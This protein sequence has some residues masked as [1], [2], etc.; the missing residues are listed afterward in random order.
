MAQ[1]K[2]KDPIVRRHPSD[3]ILVK[4]I[5]R[6]MVEVIRDLESTEFLLTPEKLG[7]SAKIAMIRKAASFLP[8]QE[9]KSVFQKEL[10][11]EEE[12]TQQ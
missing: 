7:I 4:E 2:L 9:L 5:R 6:L 12:T 1:P 10:S 8:Y 3:R 11:M